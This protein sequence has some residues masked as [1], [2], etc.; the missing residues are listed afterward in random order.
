M[1]QS[2]VVRRANPVSVSKGGLVRF[3][4]GIGVAVRIVSEASCFSPNGSTGLDIVL[5]ETGSSSSGNVS[6][7]EG[8]IEG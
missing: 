5:G 6:N 3:V 7:V 4:L 8:G 1:S 2:G